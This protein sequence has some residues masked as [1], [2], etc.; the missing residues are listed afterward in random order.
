MKNIKSLSFGVL[1]SV[2][3]FTSCIKDNSEIRTYNDEMV[4][5]N[6]LIQTLIADGYDVDTTASGVY[7]II[8]E[9]GEGDFAKIG[10]TVSINYEGYLSD[11]SMFD[12]SDDWS[13]DGVW[14]FVYGEQSLIS[15]FNEALS[16][17]NTN[18]EAEFIISSDLAY[19]A[20][21]YGYI[22]SFQTLIFGV[23]MIEIKP[24]SNE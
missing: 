5:L 18:M 6:E 21:G 8:H 16:L 23:K 7:Y 3:F 20:S 4:E 15:G 19:G 2:L 13:T 24:V 10:D 14:E 22:G 1:L 11:G 12:D 9:A 17:M